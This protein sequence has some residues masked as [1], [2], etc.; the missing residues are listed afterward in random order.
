M[1]VTIN[2]ENIAKGIFGSFRNFYNLNILLK[3][4]P[5]FMYYFINTSIN[6]FERFGMSRR[7]DEPNP[8]C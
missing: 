2:F 5:A 1:Y 8:C 4:K 3:E 6:G 7:I